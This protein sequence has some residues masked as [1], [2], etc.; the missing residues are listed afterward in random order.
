[1]Y[2]YTLDLPC[3]ATILTDS[4]PPAPARAESTK[5]PSSFI[6]LSIAPFP[7]RINK[8]H[9][10]QKYTLYH[11]RNMFFLWD[12]NLPL[13]H[14]DSSFKAFLDIT[15]KIVGFIGMIWISRHLYFRI[16]QGKTF[17]IDF[18][19]IIIINFLLIIKRYWINKN[20]FVEVIL[21]YIV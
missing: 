6:N 12:Y 15:R 1:M 7:P 5:L 11:L 16:H 2:I 13:Y 10:E 21:M 4:F 3:I 18:W 17:K 14:Y 9:H 8:G 19:F 20:D